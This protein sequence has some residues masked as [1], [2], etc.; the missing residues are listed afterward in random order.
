MFFLFI[1][2]CR[3]V[4][5]CKNLP[6]DYTPRHF[7]MGT[8]L[9]AGRT[10]QIFSY[11]S[12]VQS[13]LA[14]YMIIVAYSIKHVTC[15]KVYNKFTLKKMQSMRLKS[16]SML[17]MHFRA[18]SLKHFNAIFAE[19]HTSKQASNLFFLPVLKSPTQI[20]FD[21]WGEPKVSCLG[22]FKYFLQGHLNNLYLYEHINLRIV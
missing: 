1:I 2:S 19:I 17:S 4:L 6:S 11:K 18:L 22:P 8:K 16:W 10:N 15:R 9:Q 21:G 7:C 14:I 13:E 5:E 12:T 3:S 20:G